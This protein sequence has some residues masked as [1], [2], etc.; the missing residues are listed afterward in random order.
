M[1]IFSFNGNRIKEH[2]KEN[3]YKKT[4]DFYRAE[5]KNYVKLEIHMSGKAV[6]LVLG[7]VSAATGLN[8]FLKFLVRK[9][10][11][12]TVYGRLPEEED[13]IL[14]KKEKKPMGFACEPGL[15]EKSD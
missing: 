12:N 8:Y 11:N 13:C 10:V 3:Q 6:A 2:E 7:A 14:L 4:I 15:S 5:Q 1:K 9:L